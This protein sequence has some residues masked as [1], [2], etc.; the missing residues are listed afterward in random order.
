M[1]MEK[2]Q[3]P[4]K[5]GR[6]LL[7]IDPRQVAAMASIGCRNKEIALVLGCSVDTLDRRF[8]DEIEKGRAEGRT[9]LRRKQ[10]DAATGGNIT[11]LIWLGKQLLDQSDKHHIEAEAAN[12]DNAGLDWS[13][14]TSDERAQAARIFARMKCDDCQKG[15]PCPKHADPMT[16][17]TLPG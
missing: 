9:T 14:L 16:I 17:T 10:W 2:D 6:P 4:A 7:N 12:P 8:A 3:L 5:T 15:K 11:M 13:K 1:N